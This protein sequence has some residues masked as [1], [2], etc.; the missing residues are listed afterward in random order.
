MIPVDV[1]YGGMTFAFVEAESVGLSLDVSQE[2]AMYELG[3]RI[4]KPP[5]GNSRFPTPRTR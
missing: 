5:G 2:A 1:A 4:R 3:Q